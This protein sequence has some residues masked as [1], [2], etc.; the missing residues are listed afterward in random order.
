MSRNPTAKQR[1]AGVLVAAALVGV[2]AASLLREGTAA[3]QQYTATWW[4]LFD[5]VTTLTGYAE[6]E[7]AW[8]QQSQA[9]HD[10]LLRYHQLYDIYHHYDGMT[11]LADIN[12]ADGAAVR[13]PGEIIDLLVFAKTMYDQ[14]D[15][16]CNVAAGAVLALW[17]TARE[18]ETPPDATALQA[19]AQHCGIEEVVV[20]TDAGTVTLTDP[21]LRL[22]VGSIGKG[23]AV[24]MAAQ[25]AE[26]RGLTNALLNAGGNLR[27]IGTH[28]DGSA[29]TAAV[30]N[31]YGDGDYLARLQ[32][33]PGQSLVISGDY[34]RYFTA[35]GVRYHHLIDL[36]TLQPARYV[37]SV[38]VLCSSSAMADALSTALF[39][40]P[41]EQGLAL[42]NSLPDTEAL[43]SITQEETVQSPGW[44][45]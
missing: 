12:A 20:D 14:T 43:W 22:D 4:D 7:A 6:S 16:A 30:D 1:L 13:V 17:H 19:A 36:T 41:V 21:A 31:P 3:Q 15:G 5:T 25:A 38:A 44:P 45:G 2:A 29:W 27:A 28:A 32:L 35:D 9:L 10:D 18:T 37:H 23:Y 24:E 33:A 11:N 39:C 34:Q 8:Q 42:V 40:M 26:A